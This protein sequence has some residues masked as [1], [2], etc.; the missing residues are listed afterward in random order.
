MSNVL[1]LRTHLDRAVCSRLL[2][3]VEEANDS[4][5][6]VAGD[7]CVRRAS[8]ARNPKQTDARP[9]KAAVADLHMSRPIARLGFRARVAR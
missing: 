2:N 4:H 9:S 6:P 1:L 3:K 5:R 8:G 7:D